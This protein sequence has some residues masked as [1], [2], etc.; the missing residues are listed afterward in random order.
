MQFVD[1]CYRG[2]NV[3]VFRLDRD[4]VIARIRERARSLVER[5][6]DVREVRLFG[7]LARGEAAP[8]SDADLFVVLRDGAPPFLERIPALAKHFRGVGIGCEIIAYTES[9]R[10]ALSERRNR[11]ARAVL[12]DGMLLASAE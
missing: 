5:N 12:E 9:E 7:S 6:V 4:S 8:G 3:R 10:T 2:R 11:F 1:E